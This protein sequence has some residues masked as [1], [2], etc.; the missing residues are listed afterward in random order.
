MIAGLAALGFSAPA[1]AQD[2]DDVVD[3]VVEIVEEV[4]EEEEADT[5]VVTGSRLK[6]DTFSSFKPLQIIDFEQT[7]EVG[8]LDTIEILQTNEAAGG[9][10]FDSSFSGFVLDNGPGSETINLR[11]LGADRTLVLVNGRR[12][13]PLGV[14][15]AP[16][17]PSINSIPS[18]LVENADLLL[19]GASSVYGSDALAGVINV[20]LARDFEGFEVEGS[21]EIA[22][23]GGE[24]YTI[25][26]RYGKNFDN[27]FFGI[28]AEYDRRDRVTLADRDFFSDCTTN[29][30]IDENGQIRRNN[31]ENEVSQEL[32]GLSANPLDIDNP[33]IAAP[34]TSQFIERVAAAPFGGIFA[35]RADVGA[36]ESVTGIP[37]FTDPVIFF[38]FDADGDRVV[39]NS[40]RQF[41][42]NGLDNTRDIIAPQERF[43]IFAFGEFTIEGEAN[44]TPFFEVLHS[45]TSLE[46]DSG[47]SNIFPFVGADNPFN[48]CGVNGVD[49][50]LSAGPGLLTNP[51]FIGDFN[52]F[53]RDID[54]NRDGDTRDA[55]ICATF[56]AQIDPD[57]GLP[58]LGTGFFDNAACTPA[59]FGL[60]R[61]A[62]PIDV[63]S[64]ISL[65]NDRT[66]NEIELKQTRIVGGFKGDIPAFNYDPEGVINFSD[67][68]FEVSG[69]FSLSEGASSRT[70]IREDRLNFALG[71]SQVQILDDAGNVVTD[72]GDPIAGLAPCTTQ[73]GLNLAPDV[74]NGCVPVNLFTPNALDIRGTLA[75]SEAS[76]LFDNRDFDTEYFQTILNGFVSGKVADLPAGSV[77]A[78]LGVEYRKDEIDSVPDN[79]ASQG[80][81]FGFFSD[82]GAV[83]E[84]EIIEGFG[85]ISVPLLADQPFFE[86]LTVD[87]GFRVLDD[88]FF[89]SEAVY[90][91]SGGWRPT[92]SLLLR[93]SFGTSFRAPNLG[94]LFQLPQT[95]FV[96]VFDPCVAPDTAF[97]PSDPEDLMSP[98]VF[99][100]TADPRDP[101][102]VARCL[103][104]GVAQ[105]LGGGLVGAVSNVEVFGEGN[106]DLDPETST[107]LNIGASFEQP[108]FDAFDF[109]FGVNYYDIDVDDAVV[110]PGTQF[111]VNDCF[112]N[113]QTTRSIFCD[114]IE[115]D[116]NGFI[117]FVGLGFINLNEEEVRGLD[118][119][120]NLRYEFNAFDRPFE[121]SWSGRANHLLERRSLF[122]DDS[123]NPLEDNDEGEFGLARW[124]GSMVNRLEYKDFAFNWFTRYVGPQDQDPDGLDD[125]AN[126][127]G[128][129]TDDNGFADTTSQTCLGPNFGDVNC[130]DVG[131]AD[132][133]FVHNM[134]VSYGNADQD[135][136]VVLGVN[137]I[138]D[139][140]PPEVDGSEVTSVSNVPIGAGFNVNGRTFFASIRKAF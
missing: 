57:T 20:T 70:G 15:G 137:N 117:Q 62:G 101:N 116:Q 1:Y 43:N 102:V 98:E 19:E 79:V 2:A 135:F 47:A 13:A 131:F 81:F 87:A 52:T 69:A 89:G 109:T 84:R 27:A 90:T 32:F 39:D 74:T 34:F 58:I 55:R 78:S 60:P 119:N 9:I 5:I 67:W 96:N 113:E 61:P 26:A 16:T 71:N 11:G 108:F 128:I 8:L 65:D 110:Q 72:I 95:G 122:I 120:A 40:L 97:I 129:D 82:Q 121:Y 112:V 24:D 73:E 33:C 136:S 75:P 140:D 48:P 104:E 56:G 17:Q 31:V 42:T 66:F 45:D 51:N 138:F 130:R 23:Q 114:R 12:L 118:F 103:A 41:T 139:R 99:S 64:N 3:E 21:T 125:F 68:S 124:T 86:L 29:V 91:V 4:Q 53:Q 25:A 123:G 49:C 38:P 50:G 133:Y 77:L 54:P 83:G 76:F 115:R 37:G 63:Q 10:Q 7:R 46:I 126:A 6:K 107:S 132:D 14:E 18:I 94:E 36:D 106:L 22:E 100:E 85:E 93:A 134:T 35:N 30:E 92:E 111:V 44:I 28:A 127:F 59:L 105:D 80:L 88:E